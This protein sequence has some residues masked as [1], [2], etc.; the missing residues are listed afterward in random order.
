MFWPMLSHPQ[1]V[2]D[3][4]ED[5]MYN[6]ICNIIQKKGCIRWIFYRSRCTHNVTRTNH[7][8]YQPLSQ[9]F[10]K[11]D[12]LQFSQAPCLVYS[13]HNRNLKLHIFNLIKQVTA[14]AVAVATTTTTTKANL[15][16]EYFFLTGKTGN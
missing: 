11:T 5:K 10:K 12:I 8:K 1:A 2:E 3:C 14:I 16:P 9:T 7:I 15:L 6:C 13:F 4:T